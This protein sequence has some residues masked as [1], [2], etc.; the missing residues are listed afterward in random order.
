MNVRQPFPQATRVA[1]AGSGANK[2]GKAPRE[3]VFSVGRNCCAVTR[4][5]RVGLLVDGDEYFR[6]FVRAAEQATHH[7]AILAWDFN[8]TTRLHFDEGAHVPPARLGDFLDWLVRRRRGLHVYVLD[9]DYPVVFG[10]DREFRPLYGFGW[11]PHRHV[12]LAYDNTHPLTGSH[13]QKIVVIDDSLA[14]IGGFDLTV[15]RWDTSMH[16][17]DEARRCCADAPYPPFHD[18][19]MAVDGDAARELG[20]LV[21]SRW[22]AATGRR[23]LPPSSS[24]PPAPWPAAI[25]VDF[26]EIDV[27]FARTLPELPDRPGVAEVEALFLDM[28]AA[29]RR[30]LYIENQ[31]FTAYRVGEALAARLGE[32]DGPEIVVVVR[33]FS[34]GWLEERTMH[35]LRTRLVQRL[36]AAD[37]YGRFHIYYPHIDGL[38]DRTCIDLHSKLMIVDDEILRIGSANLCNRSMGTDSECDAAIEARGAPEISATIRSFQYRLL[39]EHLDVDAEIVAAAIDRHGSVHAAIEALAGRSRTLRALEQLPEW[40]ETMIE[41]ASVGDPE[42]PISLDGLIDDFS[43]ERFMSS[44]DD[45]D[46]DRE[47]QRRSQR[48][49]SRDGR[50]GSAHRHPWIRRGGL[51]LVGIALVIAALT[52]LWRHTPLAEWVDAAHVTALAEQFADRPWAP[53]LIVAAYTPACILMFPRPLI[54]LAS[55]VAFG[56]TLGLTYALSGILLAALST[57]VVGLAVPRQSVRKLGGDRLLHMADVLRRRSL[58]AMTAL[59]LVPLAPF[60]V[61]GMVAAAIGIRLFPFM[62]GTLFGMLPG[63]IATTVFGE[64]IGAALRDPSQINYGIIAAAIAAIAVL[65]LIVR[66]WLVAQ[67]RHSQPSGSAHGDRQPR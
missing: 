38:A 41:L 29:A 49:T 37:R 1:S 31:Y 58:L 3:S 33:L 50:P 51:R 23:L 6:A 65:S 66:R 32:P 16:A 15:R 44:D 43:P 34:H 45:A 39:A 61:E 9:W 8:S 2:A 28:I 30:C 18:L 67:H 26:R 17:A 22:L 27:A 20:T 62:L 54:T 10:A 19:M 24:T 63:T 5:N 42:R 4:A 56:P 47:N 25:P 35:V 11:R 53:I 14:F 40:P 46:D 48:G 64:Q 60:A 21:R 57:Y 13:H 12:H 55:V 7:I 52:A 36:R 59:R